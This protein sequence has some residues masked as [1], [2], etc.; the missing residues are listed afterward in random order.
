MRDRSTKARPQGELTKATAKQINSE[1]HHLLDKR[2][3]A[4]HL[5]LD[6]RHAAKHLQLDKRHA[7]KH[8]Q[9][10][11]RHAAS[12]GADEAIRRHISTSTNGMAQVQVQIEQTRGTT[13]PRSAACRK[14]ISTRLPRP[15]ACRDFSVSRNSPK[16]TQDHNVKSVTAMAPSAR[17]KQVF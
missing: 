11:K 13:V 8:L 5:Q 4:K 6:K 7:A 10:A 1:K 2:H 16:S 17:M 12:T 3:A 9:L 15:A 14:A